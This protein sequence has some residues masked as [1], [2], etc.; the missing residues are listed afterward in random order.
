MRHRKSLSVH[1]PKISACWEQIST[2]ML[3]TLAAFYVSPLVTTRLGLPMGGESP[4]TTHQY[5]LFVPCVPP[6]YK[7]FMTSFWFS[8]AG[9][10]KKQQQLQIDIAPVGTGQNH[11]LHLHCLLRSG[12]G[13]RNL[14]RPKKDFQCNVVDLGQCQFWEVPCISKNNVNWPG[15]L[16]LR[17]SNKT[18]TLFGDLQENKYQNYILKVRVQD[19]SGQKLLQYPIL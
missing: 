9:G 14:L 1:W 2:S 4:V 19:I 18:L 10:H 15:Y 17:L 3:A 11:T 6:Q 16:L 5:W 7:T 12:R 8:S 13:R